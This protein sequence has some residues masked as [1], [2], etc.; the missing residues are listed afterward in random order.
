MNDINGKELDMNALE[1]VSGG[2]KVDSPGCFPSSC[3]TALAAETAAL[4]A[5]RISRS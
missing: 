4:N 2:V 3:S 5:G 1:G